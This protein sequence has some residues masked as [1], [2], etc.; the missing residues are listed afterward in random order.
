MQVLEGLAYV[1]FIAG[2]IFAVIELRSMRKDRETDF[3]MRIN[4][5]W[6]S[7]DFE[8]A[9]VKL[10]ELPEFDDPH[11][12]EDRCGKLALYTYIDYVEGIAQLAENKSLDLRFVLTV[13]DWSGMWVKVEPW[14]RLMRENGQPA[15]A[16]SFEWLVAEDVKLISSW[17]LPD[18]SGPKRPDNR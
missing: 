16:Q 11:E 12:I 10:R 14:I 15:F 1:G 2:A 8:E 6:S 5:Y 3:L 17:D 18:Q 4:D 7:R 9:L 13:G